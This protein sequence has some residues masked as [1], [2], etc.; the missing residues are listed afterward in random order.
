MAEKH[1]KRLIYTLRLNL[2][3]PKD[4]KEDAIIGKIGD[5]SNSSQFTGSPLVMD[6]QKET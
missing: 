1:V 2:D 3:L 5:L 4:F 6:I